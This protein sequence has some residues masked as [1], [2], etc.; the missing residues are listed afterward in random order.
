MS[1]TAKTCW[2][3]VIVIVGTFLIP[4]GALAAR[5]DSFQAGTWKAP[6]TGYCRDELTYTRNKQPQW[7]YRCHWARCPHPVPYPVSSSVPP[8]V[9]V[10]A[11]TVSL[12]AMLTPSGSPRVFAQDAYR[13]ACLDAVQRAN[14]RSIL[15]AMMKSFSCSPL[16]FLVCRETVALPQPKLI[17][18]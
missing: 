14:M 5:G 2:A 8:A 11:V 13:M 7:V 4:A 18:G 16:I 3:V 1:R 17:F 12:C 10:P 9:T 6:Y 15:V